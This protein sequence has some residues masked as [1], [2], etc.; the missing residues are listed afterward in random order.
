MQNCQH[1]ETARFEIPDGPRNQETPIPQ[2]SKVVCSPLGQSSLCSNHSLLRSVPQLPALVS[3]LL[4]AREL[5]MGGCQGPLAAEVPQGMQL[6]KARIWK[7][8][9]PHL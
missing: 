8:Q 9:E 4:T 5:L 7:A 2:A 3:A 1:C 6:S